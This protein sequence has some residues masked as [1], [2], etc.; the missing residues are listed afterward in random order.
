MTDVEEE[1]TGADHA[2]PLAPEAA[3]PARRRE[4]RPVRLV[5]LEHDGSEAGGYGPGRSVAG[6][7][8]P[9][10]PPD[11]GSRPRGKRSDRD[12]RAPGELIADGIDRWLA[13]PAEGWVT[14]VV[15]VG[16]SLFMFYAV[17]PDLVFHA[18]TPTGGDM[19]AHVI[20]PKYLVE[21][22]LPHGRVTGWTPDWFAGYPLYGFYMVVPA[23]LIALLYAGLRSW[24]L[25]PALVAAVALLASGWFVPRLWRFR[26]A[27]TIVG[28]LA[29]LWAVPMQY[30]I[31]FKLVTVL[32]LWTLPLAA[33]A[34]AKLADLRFPA[35]PL[36]A[37]AA[38]FYLF[39]REPVYQGI[40]NLI[41]GNMASTMAGEYSFSI[42]LSLTLVYFG[43]LLRG[44]KTGRHRVLAGVL[45]ALVGL[46]HLLPVFFALAATLVLLVVQFRPRRVQWLAPVLVVAGSLSAFWTVP[47]L[48]NHRL[49]NDMGWDKLPYPSTN[50]LDYLLP[51]HQLWI[52]ALA[53]LGLAFTVV[54]RNRVGY[55][56]AGCV[57]VTA[58]AFCLIPE[59]QLW[60]ARILPFYY[61]SVF[62][63]AALGVTGA[64]RLLSDLSTRLDGD[65]PFG[66]R[67]LFVASALVALGAYVAFFTARPWRSGGV[68]PAVGGYVLL[69]AVALVA[70][71]FAHTEGGASG[72][73]GRGRLGALVATPLLAAVGLGVVAFPLQILPGHST[74]TRNGQ[75]VTN[76]AGA[77]EHQWLWFTSF[78]HNDMRA[79]AEWN[80]RGYEGKTG[81]YDAQQKA[82][83]HGWP[84]YKALMDTMGRIG[85]ERGC[86]RALWEQDNNLEGD[87]GTPMAL[88]LL[89]YWTNSCI[90]SEEGL[91][92]ESSSTTPY[93]WLLASQASAQPSNPQ[94][95]LP[96][97]TL[98]LNAAVPEMRLM[99][100]KYYLAESSAAVAAASKQAGLEPLATSGPWHIYRVVGSAPVQ[101]LGY[102][103]AVWDRAPGQHSWLDPA[104]SWFYD[105]GRWAI[106]FA[107]G[108]PSNW[109]RVKTDS[110]NWSTR[111]AGIGADIQHRLGTTSPDP[112]PTTPRRKVRVAKVS[113]VHLGTDTISFDVDRPGTPVLIRTSYFPNWQASGAK[114]PWRVTPNFMVVVPTSTHVRLHYGRTS[115]DW[116]AI[117]L[118]LAGVVVAL[119]LARLAPVVIGDRWP[120]GRPRYLQLEERP[121]AVSGRVVPGSAM[122]GSAASGGAAPSS[123]ASGGA[124][125]G[126]TSAEPVRPD[127]VSAPARAVSDQLRR[128]PLR[129]DQSG[130]SGSP[131]SDPSSRSDSSPPVVGDGSPLPPRPSDLSSRSDPSSPVV[132]DGSPLP[133]RPSDPSSRSD[134]SPPVVGD[135]SP[136]PPRPS[137]PSSRSDLSSPI[138]PSFPPD[139]PSP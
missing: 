12:R 5:D 135:G 101:G 13:M 102:L 22:L 62:L 76:K 87:Y 49:T 114:G 88:M 109:P 70:M 96:Y 47:F 28:V 100:V 51:Q 75:P 10:R 81:V 136:L 59:V 65:Q 14:L 118:T 34:F 98:D 139:P 85:R 108:G 132:G 67:T 91:Y 128:A 11:H 78:D 80:Y 35:P 36:F 131:S 134:S 137:D 48:W 103:P 38:L 52:A 129:A 44:F 79:W 77:Q 121:P 86:G 73:E 71:V 74:V 84:E 126:G 110:A 107:A 123:A 119:V 32:G 30:G 104:V 54:Y 29:V 115:M 124:M 45:L 66:M 7:F 83:V 99:G 31:A 37:V 39:N 19:G 93:H 97:R 120:R 138:D 21:H 130:G 41:G 92:F 33:W 42:A 53:V 105:P 17:H 117:V 125:G 94:R 50:L 127:G 43:V 72:H 15:L 89:P 46:C 23:L 64:L 25:A 122:P 6:G 27:L 56:L 1:A 57:A 58:L 111:W 26:R 112:L 18:S 9:G 4:L 20:G 95:N 24:V 69:F 2:E 3:A 113:H 40:G 82:Y 63:L 116:L 133:P 8:A 61:L 60:N 68:S 90:G 16:C 106:P 55:F